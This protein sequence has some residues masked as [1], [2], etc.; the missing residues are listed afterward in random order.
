MLKSIFETL[1][2]AG[3]GG[4]HLRLRLLGGGLV[5]GGHDEA[6]G[7]LAAEEGGEEFAPAAGAPGD[8]DGVGEAQ[9]LALAHRRHLLL[10][11]SVLALNTEIAGLLF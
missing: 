9:V 7:V 3:L 6:E 5:P 2:L 11:G 10:T 4:E 1:T 8:L